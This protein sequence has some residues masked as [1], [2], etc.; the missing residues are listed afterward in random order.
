MTTFEDIEDRLRLAVAI[1]PTDDGLLWLDQQVSRFLASSPQARPRRGWRL[2]AF[3]GA[4]LILAAS[5]LLAGAVAGAMGLF[6]RTVAPIPG[7]SMA[8][9]KA[10]VVDVSQTDAG[11]TLTLERAYVDLNQVMVFVGVEGL[12]V[13]RA[14]N[15]VAIDHLSINDA[16]LRDPTGH[17]AIMSIGLDVAEAD[18]GVAV[19]AFQFDPSTS[20]AGTYQLA[21][22]SI[23]YGGD[24]PDCVSPCV[25]D[26][27]TG[28]WRWEFELPK[29]AGIAMPTDV[30]DTEAGATLRLTDLRI[31]PTAITARIAAFIDDV[32]VAYWSFRPSR[33]DLRHGDA[34][35]IFWSGRHIMDVTPFEEGP[36]M[37]FS[38]DQ[39]AD[40]PA[41][42]WEI[43]IPELDYALHNGDEP[44]HLT[45]PWTLVVDVP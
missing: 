32:P 43:V 22:T 29:P 18:L 30:F 7:W 42:T 37:E 36:T 6:E 11:L 16:E 10:E 41:G 2:R 19:R 17:Q 8:W 44:T 5:L 21:I 35:Y 3:G 1:D 45:G 25:S 31:T 4:L 24:G 15:G 40:D 39:G 12:G 26:E 28:S 27:I 20:V 34:K 38:T 13:P 23:G 33:E 9:E 14:A